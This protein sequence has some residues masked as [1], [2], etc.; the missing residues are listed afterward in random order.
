M[1]LNCPNV[2]VTCVPRSRA[3][4]GT[5]C[6]YNGCMSAERDINPEE[7]ALGALARDVLE[8]TR[9][10][11]MVSYRF[12]D[13]ALWKMPF[14]HNDGIH[15]IGT[16][17]LAVAYHPQEVLMRY[18]VDSDE[19]VRDYLHMIAHC[20][21]YH[22]FIG[23][24]ASQEIWSLASD[25]IVEAAC[26]DLAGSRFKSAPDQQRLEV[27]QTLRGRLGNLSAEKIYS[28]FMTTGFPNN[29]REFLDALFTRDD[30]ELWYF[31]PEQ[32]ESDERSDD[33][34]H[35]QAQGDSSDASGDGQ[36]EGGEEQPSDSSGMGAGDSEQQ[37]RDAGNETDAGEGGDFSDI[38]Q[39]TE[40]DRQDWEN[41]SKQI[42][43]DLETRSQTY[44]KDA[45]TM[46]EQLSIVNRQRHD[47]RDFLRRFAQL[48]EEMTVND[49]EFDLIYYTFGLDRFGNMP[50][51]EPLEYRESEK[52]RDFV[53]AI[54]TSQSVEGALVRHFVE[55]TFTLLTSTESFFTKVNIHIIQ[56]DAQ[57]QKVVRLTSREE[58]DTYMANFELFGF[59]GTD[60]RPV[61][62]YVDGLIEDGT[63]E[64]LRGLIYF[65]DG[66]GVFPEQ[67]PSYETVFMF[68]EDEY[69]VPAVPP[70]A[71]R[72]IVEPQDIMPREAE[73]AS[74]DDENSDVSLEG[75]VRS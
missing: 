43:V 7:D 1:G 56:C 60:F 17:A 53:I 11:L 44:G 58:L 37:E 32:R 40:A 26:I 39:P 19:F 73:A 22:P 67:P 28:Y 15:L 34:R 12:L 68:L 31:A 21:F 14:V 70:W 20:I 33:V 75:H 72:L 62:K 66:Y 25:I 35:E 49:D 51:I 57:I 5:T 45:G 55:E 30:H 50:L 23:K 61:F 13:R 71:L 64:E 46:H 41:I 2:S 65:T 38:P 24:D 47:Y 16:N 4:L 18:A 59:G 10:T 42:K 54:D 52:I 48:H 8:S 29:E 74:V 6:A 9:R 69:A 3:L 36:G 63:I 27:I